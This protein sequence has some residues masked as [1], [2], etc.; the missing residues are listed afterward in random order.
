MIST[1]IKTVLQILADN[2]SEQK[3]HEFAEKF[4]QKKLVERYLK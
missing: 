1:K 2:L 3:I 4:G